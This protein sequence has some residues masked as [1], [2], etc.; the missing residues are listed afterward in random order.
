MSGITRYAPESVFPTLSGWPKQSTQDHRRVIAAFKE[1][2]ASG[3]RS[4]MAEHFTVGVAPLTEHLVERGV[5][6]DVDAARE[7]AV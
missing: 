1:R 2:D 4:A 6:V 3:A 5:I 7:N